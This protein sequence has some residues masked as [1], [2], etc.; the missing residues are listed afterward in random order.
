LL[1]AIVSVTAK[2]S[3]ID[4]LVV[5]G[6]LARGDVAPRSHLAD[7]SEREREVLSEMAQGRS[8]HAI[9]E[10][11]YISESAVEKH[12]TAVFAKLGLDATDGS[13]NRRV[14]A[15]LAFLQSSGRE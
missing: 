9:A 14:A 6:L 15:V 11:L 5:E 4:P 2:G 13:V 10:S 7:L 8:N 1:N 12:V 3:V